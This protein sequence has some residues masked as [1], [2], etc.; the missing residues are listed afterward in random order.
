M[1]FKLKKLD[2]LGKPYAIY[3]DLQFLESGAIDQFVEAMQQ[4]CVVKG[5]L[6]PDAHSGYT[7]PIGAVVATRDMIFPSYVG[8]DIGCGMCAVP[9][10]FRRADVEAHAQA[11]FDRIYRS[12]PTGFSSNSKPVTWSYKGATSA[13]VKGLEK[14]GRPQAQ[15]G[16]LG[17]GNHFIELGCDEQDRV[18]IV[19][20]SG[21]RGVGHAI[22]THYMRLA[23]GDGKAREGHY[24]LAVTSAEGCDYI[25]DLAYGLQFALDNRQTMI[26]RVELAM[27][28]ALEGGAKL[29]FSG[30]VLWSELINRNHNH[31]ELRTIELPQ[32]SQSVWIHRKGATHAD[33]GMLGIVPGNMRDGSFVIR[34][35]GNPDSLCSS[36]HGAGRVLSRSKA[37]AQINLE[38]FQAAM[39]GIQ[40]KVDVSTLD[41]SPFAYKSIFEVMDLQQDL[42][43]VLHHIK[44]LI[45][46][47]GAGK[48]C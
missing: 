37:K 3:A 45:N 14:E 13:F 48:D 9:T 25:K 29:G 11:I 41:E 10:T 43:E 15:L 6:M 30:Q 20:H 24:G 12:V 17:G 1:S 44:P 26:S 2:A 18:W 16:T 23:A 27:R 38:D 22:A 21:S 19:I 35:K 32:G 46:I 8:Y 40:A 47:K 31:A 5:A 7:L 33:E 36:S 42:V 39:V 4:D 34:G 28:S